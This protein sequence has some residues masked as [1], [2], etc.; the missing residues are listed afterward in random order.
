MVLAF[1][2]ISPE[3]D[4]FAPTLGRATLFCED[5]LYRAP[6]RAA[7]VVIDISPSNNVSDANLANRHISPF[8]KATALRRIVSW[9]IHIGGDRLALNRLTIVAPPS[10]PANPQQAE[11]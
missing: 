11:L 5:C 2:L 6:Q 7:L 8:V 3:S 1:F 10:A 9:S 4:T